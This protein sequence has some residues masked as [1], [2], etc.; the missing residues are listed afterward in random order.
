MRNAIG[1]KEH[2][3]GAAQ[4]DAFRAERPRLYGVAGNIG[5]GAHLHGAEWLAPTQKFL[6]L[7]IIR[8]SRHGV[9]LAFQHASGAAIE[10]DPVAF[11]QNFIL[12]PHDALL[13]IHAELARAHH[14][15][16]AHAASDHGGVAG[17]AAARGKNPCRHLHAVNVFRRG[18]RAH[19]NDRCLAV[20]A[21]AF[22]RI[23]GG[24]CDLPYGRAR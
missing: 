13:L 18:L 21:G 5:V 23:F 22:D 6:Q 17:H 12:H 19:Q 3:L 11:L 14:A 16:F 2:V 7:G 10:R 1:S 24:K 15:A 4:S 20:F 8:R 9:Q